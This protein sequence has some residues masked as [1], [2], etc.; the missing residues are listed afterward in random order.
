MRLR[1]A[2]V[3]GLLLCLVGTC[4]AA[5][6]YVGQNTGDNAC[7]VATN[8]A[9]RRL[10]V[11]KGIECMSPGDTLIIGNGVYDEVIST[12]TNNEPAAAY[13]RFPPSGNGPNQ[14]TKIWAENRRGAIFRVHA[15]NPKPGDWR[16]ILSVVNRQYMHFRG[17]VLDAEHTVP[18]N[19]LGMT[20]GINPN[21]A[22]NILFED[23]EIVDVR[24]AVS[25]DE[26]CL[27]NSTFL[28]M[29]V[30]KTG[31]G[32]YGDTLCTSGAGP[33]P[34]FCH[35]FY[36][37]SS[38]GCF[39]P[40]TIDGGKYYDMNGFLFQYTGG[41]TVKNITMYDIYDIVFQSSITL[42]FYN[43]TFRNLKGI[44]NFTGG[45]NTFVHNTF[46]KENW[47][48]G[49]VDSNTSA[50]DGLGYYGDDVVKNNIFAGMLRTPLDAHGGQNSGNHAG[51][52]CDRAGENCA[53]FTPSCWFD[54]PDNPNGGNLHL[55][56]TSPAI[57][58]GVNAGISPDKD[59]NTRPTSGRYDAGAY[60]FVTGIGNQAPGIQIVLPTQQP[61]Y[62][63]ATTPLTISGSAFDNG[64]LNRVTWTCPTCT[65]SCPAAGPVACTASGTFSW[66][67]SVGTG[68]GANVIDVTVYDDIE[69]PATDRI[70]ITRPTL[71]TAPSNL[72]I[73]QALVTTTLLVTLLWDHID[74][75]GDAPA[76]GFRLFR[77]P[78]CTGNFVQSGTTLPLS[79]LT[80]TESGLA[81]VGSYCW[82]IRAVDAGGAESPPSNVE[83]W[84]APAPVVVSRA[85]VQTSD[86]WAVF[87]V[88][89]TTNPVE[90]TDPA[91][92]GL[93]S[94]WRVLP[95]M[96]GGNKWWDLVGG[97]YAD[98]L[99][100]TPA[101]GWRQTNRPGGQGQIFLDSSGNAYLSAGTRTGI[102]GPFS[103][104][105]WTRQPMG[106]TQLDFAG[107]L[108]QVPS[109]E[110]ESGWGLYFHNTLLHCFV[111]AYN[112]HVVTSLAPFLPT[113]WQHVACTWDGVSIRLYVDGVLQGTTGYTGSVT[114]GS[115]FDIGLLRDPTATWKGAFDDI[116]LYT[117]G[118]STSEV[119][120]GRMLSQQ[121]QPGLLRR[122]TLG[123][124]ALPVL[125]APPVIPSEGF[126]S[127]PSTLMLQR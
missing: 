25:E 11:N 36:G 57:G 98:L 89:D 68:A 64:P 28:N 12:Y 76:V 41:M 94:W 114:L 109:P 93:K 2:W 17:L 54:A 106:I 19:A 58:A 104:T 96:E 110:W 18:G 55:C 124:P 7:N 21:N 99:N 43:N 9:T 83:R 101:S 40:N 88:V 85:G 35:F 38:H 84:D 49:T 87:G 62:S 31:G 123:P 61:T 119:Q 95:G 102:T 45:G 34:G 97:A 5:T 71:P 103:V 67:F 65:P 6:Y 92:H 125:A 77:Q 107:I 29:E 50:Q 1:W 46:Y 113:Q 52:V 48:S 56:S 26:Q 22:N 75:A 105:F 81:P 8:P 20:G 86:P 63:T 91:A 79:P 82:H 23:I 51:N 108:G 117:R 69:Q 14:M 53:V 47:I 74:L 15:G 80:I 16:Y 121:G 39:G 60:Q 30:H 116:K 72:R 4:D 73:T 126:R 90:R 111:E 70:T 127:S 66:S 44:G 78:N 3:V 112:G 59:G 32:Q 118:L 42:T 122:V 24:T 13:L 100:M 120:T 33:W 37:Q 27:R 115:P 10:T